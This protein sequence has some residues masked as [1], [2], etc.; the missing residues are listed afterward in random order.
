METRG[1]QQA[2]KRGRKRS[3]GPRYRAL[4]VSALTTCALLVTGLVFV[5]GLDGALILTKLIVPLARLLLVICV[6]LFVG[7]VLESA[8]WIRHLAVLARP[9]FSFANLGERCSAAF[10]TAFISGVASN[11]M[12]LGFYQDGTITKRQL[13]LANL[14]NQLPAFFLHLP[15]TF[16]IV[17]PL[18]GTAGL[19]Y[20]AITFAATILRTLIFA[21]YGHFSIAPPNEQSQEGSRSQQDDSR[22][23]RAI[24]DAVREKLPARLTG[25]AI[26]LLPIYTAVFL[27]SMLGLF[28]RANE[29][30]SSFFVTGF[31]PIEALSVVILSFA[32]EFTSGFA[33]AGAMLDA[34]V[35]SVQQTVIALIAGNILAFPLRALRHQLPR[36]IGIFSARM[37]TEILLLGQL[38]RIISLIAVTTIYYLLS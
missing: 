29:L 38:F 37:G 17:V 32:A 20:F 12:L 28:D 30:L 1:E 9:L 35:I 33:A 8:G 26:L 34:G 7:Q 2:G 4:L 23:P 16:F 25:V 27:I 24:L 36:Y 13:Y 21:L 14:I 6:G 22:K 11:S 19:I 18:T 31:V 3:R 10:T 15:T 5:D